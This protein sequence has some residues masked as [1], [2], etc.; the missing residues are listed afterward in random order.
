MYIRTSH[1][2]SKQFYCFLHVAIVE[3]EGN[4]SNST[5]E[6]ETSDS[7]QTTDTAIIAAVTSAAILLVLIGV[8][9][10]I[11]AYGVRQSRTVKGIPSANVRYVSG[12]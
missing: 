11:I 5:T 10:L 9:I 4:F 7:Q 6:E 3:I 12:F 1:S 2:L 8:I